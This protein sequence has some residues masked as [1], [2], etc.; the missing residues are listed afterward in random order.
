M[1]GLYPGKINL[2]YLKIFRTRKALTVLFNRTENRNNLNVH[3]NW[4][5]R[6]W[7]SHTMD[8]IQPLKGPW[9]CLISLRRSQKMSVK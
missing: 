6:L 2:G 1:S 5:N 9:K 3:M 7:P 8:C 4:L